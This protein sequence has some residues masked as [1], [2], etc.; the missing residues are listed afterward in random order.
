MY[1]IVCYGQT[2]SC[3]VILYGMN[4]MNLPCI[5][6]KVEYS[7][8]YVYANFLIFRCEAI[9]SCHAPCPLSRHSEAQFVL[10]HT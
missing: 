3:T 6:S 10:K 2:Y 4:K 8:V 7:E 1:S 5:C 9:T